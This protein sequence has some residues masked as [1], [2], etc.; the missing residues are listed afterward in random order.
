MTTLPLNRGSCSVTVRPSRSG[1][2]KRNGSVVSALVFSVTVLRCGA[3]V[4]RTAINGVWVRTPAWNRPRKRIRLPFA[5]AQRTGEQVDVG[6]VEVR[7]REAVTCHP[8]GEVA[9]VAG[10]GDDGALEAGLAVSQVDDPGR[11]AEVTDPHRVPPPDQPR[12]RTAH[13]PAAARSPKR[14]DPGPAIPD[15]P[16]A[17]GQRVAA[18]PCRDRRGIVGHLQ[19]DAVA[20]LRDRRERLAPGSV[21]ESAAPAAAV[22]LN[23]DA[24]PQLAARELECRTPFTSRLRTRCRQCERAHEREDDGS[25]FASNPRGASSPP[26]RYCSPAST[27]ASIVLP[28]HGAGQGNAEL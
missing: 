8:T 13:G 17:A 7:Q 4:L 19:H 16:V 21:A 11:G 14:D 3:P 25:H 26:P 1:K 20:G 10:I 27:L 6:S 18:D 23:D 2:A 24:E 5:A 28:R 15:V 22:T 9:I 12:R